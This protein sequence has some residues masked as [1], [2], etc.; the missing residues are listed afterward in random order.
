MNRNK[1]CLV[2]FKNQHQENKAMILFPNSQ[3]KQI[4]LNK[5]IQMKTTLILKKAF[6]LL[7]KQLMLNKKRKII[8]KKKFNKKN[9]KIK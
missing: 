1:I 6:L 2:K 5:R 4:R 9:K 8:F 7:Q 3:R